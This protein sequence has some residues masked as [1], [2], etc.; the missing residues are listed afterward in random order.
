MLVRGTADALRS[1][2]ER[3]TGD[4]PTVDDEWWVAEARRRVA[5]GVVD[6]DRFDPPYRRYGSAQLL[7][8]AE[9]SVPASTPPSPVALHGGARL[10][11]LMIDG[12]EVR[13]FTADTRAVAGDPYRDLAT[14]AVD[15]AVLVSPEALGPFLDA[16]GARPPDIVRIDFH[17]LVDQLLR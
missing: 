3:P 16:Y 7:S 12:G 14:L 2:H 15:L 17:T 6:P 1:L 4:R 10:D 5:A 8:I 13:G 11:A 9:R